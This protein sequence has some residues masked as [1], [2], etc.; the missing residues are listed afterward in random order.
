MTQFSLHQL[1]TEPTYVTEHSSSLLD[2][3]LVSNPFSALFTDVGVPLLEQVRY[4]LPVIDLLHHSSKP[5]TSYKRKIFLYDKGDLDSYR[6]QLTDVDWEIMFGHDDVDTIVDIIAN[7]I[8]NIADNTIPNRF[9][10]VRKDSRPWITTSIM[11]RKNRIHKK[12]KHTNSINH[13]DKYRITRNKCNNLIKMAKNDYCSIISEKIKAESSGRKNWWNL[14]KRL[15]LVQ[16][17]FVQY[18]PYKQTMT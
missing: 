6:Q 8:L 11:R 15:D 17:K 7:T 5:L 2:L 14:V 3:I 9:I 16:V 18:P 4:H 10:T 13:W 1:I 12:A